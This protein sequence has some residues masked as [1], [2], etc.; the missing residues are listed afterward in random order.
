MLVF[1]KLL[2]FNAISQLCVEIWMCLDVCLYLFIV[3]CG[4]LILIF[5]DLCWFVHSLVKRLSVLIFVTWLIFADM[6][7]GFVAICWHLLIFADLCYNL[8]VV[9][10]CSHLSPFVGFCFVYM[11]LQSVDIWWSCSCLLICLYLLIFVDLCWCLLIFVDLC[12]YFVIFVDS[13]VY[14]LSFVG[15]CWYVLK[16]VGIWWYLLII[17]DNCSYLLFCLLTSSD[18][19]WLLLM[20]VGLLWYLTNVVDLNNW[21]TA[22]G[23]SGALDLHII[24]PLWQRCLFV[25]FVLSF[26]VMYMLICITC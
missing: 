9:D 11:G 1:V 24:S 14:L 15:V 4:L 25:L 5:V 18:I 3:V 20:C 2:I 19:C 6:Y 7:S 8:F 13:C 17:A 22:K 12:C 10:I 23:I 26:D 21:R 16:F